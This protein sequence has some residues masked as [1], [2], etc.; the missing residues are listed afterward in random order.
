MFFLPPLAA[1]LLAGLMWARA[2]RRPYRP[3]DLRHIWLA[4]LAFLPQLAPSQW[5]GL[6]DDLAAAA[7]LT[8]HALLLVFA[9]LNWRA[10]GMTIVIAGVICNL[11]VM[12]ANGG[13]MPISPQTAERLRG[14][15]DF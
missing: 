4:P 10:P 6:S 9:L 12:S 15:R 11:A 2:K 7:L 1:G 8:S 13:F 5:P 14:E 3:P